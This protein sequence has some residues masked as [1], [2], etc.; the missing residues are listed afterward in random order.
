M[1]CLRKKKNK[2]QVKYQDAEKTFKII[3]PDIKGIY[4]IN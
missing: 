3:S 2:L 1:P 4:E